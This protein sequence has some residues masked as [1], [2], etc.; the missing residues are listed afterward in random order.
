MI[1]LN[2]KVSYEKKKAAV[3]KLASFRAVTKKG[4]LFIHV[5]N[6]MNWIEKWS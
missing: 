2:L 6:S 4:V 3:T 1:E 5:L